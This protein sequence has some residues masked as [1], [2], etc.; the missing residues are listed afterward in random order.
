M[1]PHLHVYRY[2]KTTKLWKSLVDQSQPRKEITKLIQ[3]KIDIIEL[4]R[5]QEILEGMKL[6]R[7]QIMV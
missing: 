6:N 7:S 4:Y 5:R 2:D 3:L 1:E